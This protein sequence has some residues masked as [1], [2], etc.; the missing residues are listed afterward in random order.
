MLPDSFP[1]GDILSP[2]LLAGTLRAMHDLKRYQYPAWYTDT[3]LTRPGYWQ[4]QG[5]YVWPVFQPF[6]YNE[7]FK[8]FL[9][10]GI[11]LSPEYGIPSIIPAEASPGELHKLQELFN[12]APGP[13]TI[14]SKVH[15]AKE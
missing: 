15:Q 10:E 3:L 6:L 4:Q 2:V 1:E 11:L 5:L 7:V 9:Q 12:L 13:M 14:E 8:K